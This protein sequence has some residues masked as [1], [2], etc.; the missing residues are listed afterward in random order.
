MP[1]GR[2]A[3]ARTAWET[4]WNRLFNSIPEIA[5]H[6]TQRLFLSV[7]GQEAYIHIQQRM[8]DPRAAEVAVWSP[9]PLTVQVVSAV[10]DWA[11]RE[12]YRSLI[13]TVHDEERAALGSEADPDGYTQ[14]TCSLVLNDN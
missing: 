13:M 2:V 7:A 14:E 5:A 1:V 12:G 9:K 3:S 8:Y 10:R 4:H 11:H 6:K